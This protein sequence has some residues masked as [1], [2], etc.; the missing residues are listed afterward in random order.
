MKR[1]NAINQYIITTRSE[2]CF[3]APRQQARCDSTHIPDGEIIA[4][5]YCATGR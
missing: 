1:F 3:N 2:K 4:A 5:C